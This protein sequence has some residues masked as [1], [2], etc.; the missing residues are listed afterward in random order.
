V[1]AAL[2]ESLALAAEVSSSQLA[3][4]PPPALR[5]LAH[6]IQ[7]NQQVRPAE[8]PAARGLP[9]LQRLLH[10]PCLHRVPGPCP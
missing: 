3:L 2:Q 9:C 7:S 10:P 5:A 1:V 8:A 6:A 4:E